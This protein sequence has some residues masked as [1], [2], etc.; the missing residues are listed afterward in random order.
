MVLLST[1]L[2]GEIAERRASRG[3]RSRGRERS[4]ESECVSA[5]EAKRAQDKVNE[6][7]YNK[8]EEQ[9]DNKHYERHIKYLYKSR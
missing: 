6:I 1:R 9:L 3:L 5:S 8:S 7:K 2:F 4:E